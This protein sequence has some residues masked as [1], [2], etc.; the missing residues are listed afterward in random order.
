MFHKFQNQKNSSREITEKYVLR[1]FLKASFLAEI[2]N[3]LVGARINLRV[4]F[5][6]IKVHAAACV[7]SNAS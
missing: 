2:A 7:A 4:M 6:L 3:Q 5:T 1:A